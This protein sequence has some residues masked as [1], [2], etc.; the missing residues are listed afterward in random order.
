ME[1]E[2]IKIGPHHVISIS[3]DIDLYNVSKMKSALFAAADENVKSLV[4]DMKGI[5]Y[6]D[7]SGIGALVAVQKKVRGDK[8]SFALVNVNPDVMEILR[9][10]SLHNFFNIHK[11]NANLAAIPLEKPIG[12]SGD[13]EAVKEKKIEAEAQASPVQ[14]PA[15]NTQNNAADKLTAPEAKD[16]IPAEEP[17]IF[18]GWVD[19][20][21]F[22][23]PADGF[24]RKTTSDELQRKMEAKKSAIKTAQ[25]LALE[26]FV[27]P[28]SSQ[29]WI[30]FQKYRKKVFSKFSEII[31][32]GVAKLTKFDSKQN[33]TIIYEIRT[34]GLKDKVFQEF[35]DNL[36]G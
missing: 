2:K 24:P 36:H 9:L 11:A 29:N 12:S 35:H 20:N 23:I 7:S 21:T 3:G 34:A 6:I 33:C 22:R 30:Q 19:G 5:Y 14:D 13:T 16:F 4:L 8:G 10:A 18:K 1:I 28:F 15:D 27:E 26:H 17:V 32:N 25:M 31:K